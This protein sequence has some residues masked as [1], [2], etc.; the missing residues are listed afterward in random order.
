[1]IY[2]LNIG[3]ESYMF[4][5]SRGLQT[6]MDALAKARKLKHLIIRAAR[7]ITRSDSI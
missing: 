5:S 2:V 3:Y 6:V 7:N 4:A 1:M